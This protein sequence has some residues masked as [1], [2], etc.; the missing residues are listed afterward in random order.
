MAVAGIVVDAVPGVEDVAAAPLKL[1]PQGAPE[2]VIKLLAGVV[3]KVDGGVLLLLRIGGHHQHRLALPPPEEI[4][5]MVVGK[6]LPAL[7]GQAPALAD[8]AVEGELGG[9]PGDKL[10]RIHPQGLGAFHQEGVG[11][12]VVALLQAGVFRRV[13]H[14]GGGHLLH[15]DAQNLPQA[16][17]ALRDFKQLHFHRHNT[18]CFLSP[19]TQKDPSHGLWDGPNGSRYHPT[20]TARAAPLC[21]NPTIPGR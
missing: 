7:D 10:H 8:D 18:S 9:L 2:D 3:G 21:R 17:D 11:E 16:A 6:T 19:S 12:V 4:A 5:H 20:C 13:H 15:G 14:A 1:H